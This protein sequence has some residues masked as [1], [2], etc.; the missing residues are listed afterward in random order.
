MPR[1][2]VSTLRMSEGLDGPGDLPSH[3]YLTCS[4]FAAMPHG[5]DGIS[6]LVECCFS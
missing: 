6:L 1:V 2:E 5:I 4:H 3:T